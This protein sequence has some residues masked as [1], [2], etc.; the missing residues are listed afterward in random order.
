MIEGASV[1]YVPVLF[2]LAFRRFRMEDI[3]VS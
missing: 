2:T 3:I 1:S